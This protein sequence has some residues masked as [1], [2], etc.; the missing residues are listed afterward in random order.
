MGNKTTRMN[1]IGIS[2]SIKGI[3]KTDTLIKNE[4][5]NSKTN[6]RISEVNTKPQLRLV[7]NGLIPVFE[8]E[9]NLEVSS[10]DLHK[11]LQ[12]KTR[13]TQWMDEQIEFLELVEGIDFRSFSQ[14]SEKPQGGR[15]KVNHYFPID[16]AKE[17]AMISR[18]RMG[19]IIRKYFIET[20]KAYKEGK[21]YE[22]VNGKTPA[23]LLQYAADEISKRDT[24]ISQQQNQI[25]TMKPAT[26]MIDS[27]FKSDVKD[28]NFNTMAKLSKFTNPSNNGKIGGKLLKD[29]CID[30][31]IVNKKD[32]M[33]SQ[34]Y[35]NKG[36]FKVIY[37]HM[38]FEGGVQKVPT[39]L[40]TPKGQKWLYRKINNMLSVAA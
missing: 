30:L 8:N 39:T 11:Q 26:Q 32:R 5:I 33:P 6:I 7:N 29:L 14:K 2:D 21:A 25:E 4:G 23:E 38:W 20:E 1:T 27:F 18:T 31:K 15:P 12:V 34:L 17:I 9:G 24:L 36:Y 10:E 19:K 3:S 35:I 22:F 37:K 28:I 13:K 16:I 40:I